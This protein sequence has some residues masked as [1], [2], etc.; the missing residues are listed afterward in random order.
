VQWTGGPLATTIG[1]AEPDTVHTSD[2]DIY[3]TD[4]STI[5]ASTPMIVQYFYYGDDDGAA[6]NAALHSGGATAIRLPGR[7]GTTTEIDLPED[8]TGNMQN[9][10]LVGDNFTSTGLYA[11]G[12]GSPHRVGNPL[13][14]RV[15]YKGL[16]NAFGGGA[17][18][19]FIDGLG[20]PEG[21]GYYGYYLNAKGVPLGYVGPITTSPPPVPVFPAAGNVIEV[22]GGKYIRFDNVYAEDSQGTGNSIYQCGIDEEFPDPTYQ[23]ISPSAI[24]N[25]IM[26]NSRFDSNAAF[27]GA[28]NP[29]FAL[30]LE[31]SCHD[32]V[33][34]SVVAYD[35]MRADIFEYNG[36]LF[37]KTHLGSDAAN[38]TIT[39]GATQINWMPI[40]PPKLAGVADYG[41]FARGNTSLS[42]TQCDIANTACVYVGVNGGSTKLNPA[43][44]TD[45]QMKCG[46]LPNVPPSYYGVELAAGTVNTTV[47]G[48]QAGG[49]CNIPG[50]Q[51]VH[52]DAPPLD[53][54][55]S[56]CNNS[57]AS[58]IFC[59]P[60][61]SGFAAG[62][63]YTQPAPVFSSTTSTTLGTLYAVPFVT[64]VG[65]TIT[66]MQIDVTAAPTTGT[67]CQ[68]GIY[69][70]SA[71][72]PGALVLDAGLT[73]TFTIAGQPTISGLNVLLSPGALYFLVVGCSQNVTLEGS[74][75]GG[76]LSGVLSGLKA[77]N[78]PNTAITGA[79]TVTGASLPSSFPSPTALTGT[80]PNVYVLP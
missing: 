12:S 16:Q 3:P 22:D 11:F 33:Y 65:G 52:V 8:T 30:K 29:D 54:S 61:F 76:N 48:T 74:A 25:I 70:S 17:K 35:G 45:T 15:L 58:V 44:V 9:A 79:W 55:V 4:S 20:I 41:V 34:Q 26:S 32:S 68:L 51:L 60:A 64:P 59:A 21:Y 63:A 19:M 53:T 39:P 42:Q 23:P 6:I 13:L 40:N 46:S 43:Q 75:S 37:S 1:W 73:A 56:I 69:A 24:G 66:K 67:Y 62:Q 49:S 71:G 14:S 18:N 50:P 7:C 5:S 2:T 77:V 80:T 47:S 57:N 78:N 36:N 10:A 31:N 72:A 28:T 27:S 38:G